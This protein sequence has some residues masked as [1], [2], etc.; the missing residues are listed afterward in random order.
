MSLRTAKNFQIPAGMTL[1]QVQQGRT[2]RVHKRQ[3]GEEVLGDQ[4]RSFNGDDYY[5][6]VHR[7]PCDAICL[8]SDHPGDLP[9]FTGDWTLLTRKE[10]CHSV[11]VD[12]SRNRYWC[13]WCTLKTM[14][15]A[16]ASYVERCCSCSRPLRSRLPGLV[17]NHDDKLQA[18]I[19]NPSPCLSL[20]ELS[21]RHLAAFPT[22]P[23]SAWKSAARRSSTQT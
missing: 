16:L 7:Q 20:L 19:E 10:N 1:S 22:T 12:H 3:T 17:W 2:R 15:L 11:T 8:C 21:P 13:I 5:R 9:E 18:K 4:D 14:L 6:E 23:C